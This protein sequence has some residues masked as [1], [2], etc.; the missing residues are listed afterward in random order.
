VNRPHPDRDQASA[1]L[2]ELRLQILE[3]TVI[4]LGTRLAALEGIV[5]LQQRGF[6]CSAGS[7][8]SLD[9][10]AWVKEM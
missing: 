10:C 5:V 8:G 9:E 2:L 4:E 1:A 6:E 7:N 3:Q